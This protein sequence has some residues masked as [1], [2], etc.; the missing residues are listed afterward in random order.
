MSH[1]AKEAPIENASAESVRAL[2]D[3]S[4]PG[5]LTLL[6]VRMEPEYEEFHLPGATLVPLP[7]LPDRL[8][9]IDKTRPVVVYCRGG[10]RSAAAA[11]LLATAGFPRIVNMLGGAMAW[12]GAAATGTPDAGL[13]LLRGDETPRQI[14]LAALGMEAALGAFYEKLA[15]AANDGETRSTFDRLAGFEARHLHHVHSLYDKETGERTDLS[16]LLA[17]AAPELEGGLPGSAFLQ[18]LG[19]DPASPDEALELAASV[20]AQAL[21]LYARLA[22]RTADA[23]SKTLYTTLAQEEKAHLRAVATLLSRLSNN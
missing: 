22:E 13:T 11:R 12:Q 19:G 5:E 6:D 1:D 3:A 17:D 7:E 14:L 10:M 20:E 23:D 16:A 21:D 18:Q 4:R 2:L 15:A 8:G 9:E